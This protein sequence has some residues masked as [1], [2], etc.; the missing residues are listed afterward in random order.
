MVT[1]PAEGSFCGQQKHDHTST[2]SVADGFENEIQWPGG[3]I[4]GK[5]KCLPSLRNG[6]QGHI[7]LCV[8]LSGLCQA[9]DNSA[10]G[11]RWALPI[12]NERAGVD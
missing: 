10:R 11:F 6:K 5:M 9:N 2:H 7:Q 12:S 3:G 1:Q 8:A 4:E